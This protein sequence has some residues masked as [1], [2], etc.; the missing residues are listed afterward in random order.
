MKHIFPFILLLFLL[1]TVP[2]CNSS[3]ITMEEKPDSS[4][5][6][7]D[8][9]RVTLDMARSFAASIKERGPIESEECFSFR[10]DTLIYL[11]NYH[12]GWI[13]V[14]SDTRTD[15]I[16]ASN[17]KGQFHFKQISSSIEGVWYE[18]VGQNLWELRN[19]TVLPKT[20][21][22]EENPWEAFNRLPTRDSIPDYPYWIREKTTDVTT[23]IV[24]SY[25]PLT[26]TRWGQDYPWNW[27]MFDGLGSDGNQHKCILGCASVAM[28]QLLYYT[29]YY[30]GKPTG[31]YHDISVSG[32]KYDLNTGTQVITRGNFTANSTR[33]DDMAKLSSDYHID[34]SGD[35]IIDVGFRLPT[36][37]WVE[38]SSADIDESSF[39]DYGVS[40]DRISYNA[41]TVHHYLSLGN[42]ILIAAYELYKPWNIFNPYQNG[43]LWIIDGWKTRLYSVHTTYHWY[44]ISSEEDLL[45]LSFSGIID[46]YD[47]E[48]G[49]MNCQGQEYTYQNYS[50]TTPFI[51]MN[52]GYSG[53]D[54]T[55]EYNPYAGSVWSGGGSDYQYNKQIFYHFR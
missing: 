13:M 34:Y 24:E 36:K 21:S 40:C 27:E 20:R 12:D 22:S 39:S 6:L 17:E 25:G 55:N 28:S 32:F 15:P 11:F 33:W 19:N 47:Y 9:F 35:F 46:R 43:H 10:G 26:Q 18:S 23:S 41:D 30:L 8:D 29:H 2:S 44:L 51:L 5:T 50:Y 1:S 53:S 48:T 7:T 38:E 45:N 31:L 49:Y 54:D 4:I 42:P 52:W 37:Y 16:L 14:S 3:L